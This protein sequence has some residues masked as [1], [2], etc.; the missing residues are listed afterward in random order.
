M[1]LKLKIRPGI[2]I[3]LTITEHITEVS[4]NLLSNTKHLHVMS[5]SNSICTDN[6]HDLYRDTD[7]GGFQL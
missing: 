7:L 5:F 4:H 6:L 1:I 3:R 2:I